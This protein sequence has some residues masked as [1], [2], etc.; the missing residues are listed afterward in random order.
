MKAKSLIDICPFQINPEVPVQMIHVEWVVILI[1]RYLFVLRRLFKLHEMMFYDRIQRNET[2]AL[3]RLCTV[4]YATSVKKPA[5]F[6]E[7][8]FK[9][10]LVPTKSWQFSSSYSSFDSY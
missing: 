2:S 1:Q 3:N 5:Y 4:T 7:T 10:N 9:V 8:C 6:H